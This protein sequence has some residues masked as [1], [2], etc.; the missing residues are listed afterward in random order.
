MRHSI[1][2]AA[3]GPSAS[4]IVETFPELP[5]GTVVARA[6]LLDTGTE[7]AAAIRTRKL[8]EAGE[9]PLRAAFAA[10]VAEQGAEAVIGPDWSAR[11]VVDKAE[12]RQLRFRVDN[13]EGV[14]E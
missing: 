6:G 9:K 4:Q 1:S 8:A 7:Y 5:A 11:V 13:E 14:S 2:E 3:R 10:L 12:R